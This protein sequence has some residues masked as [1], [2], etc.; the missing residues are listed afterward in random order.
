MLFFEG[1]GVFWLDGDD[2]AAVGERAIAAS[3]AH[4]IDDH[5]IVHG[6]GGDDPAARAH[7]KGVNAAV[8][9]LGG[10]AVACGGEEARALLA[11]RDVV[12]NLVDHRLGMLDAD[13]DGEGFLFEKD[14]A[15]VKEGVDVARAVA[16]GKNDGIGFEGSAIGTGDGAGVVLIDMN[17]GNFGE[18]MDF[19]AVV[20]DGVAQGLDDVGE[21]IRSDVGVGI[22]EDFFWCAVGDENLVDGMD[23]TAFGSAG[24]EFAI[25]EGASAAFAEA[26]VAFLD[27]AAF[28][29]EGREIEAASASIFSSFE[30][31]GFD[32]VF[33]AAESGE[34][35]GGTAADDDG[36][37]RVCWEGWTVPGGS[38]L[39]RE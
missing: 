36:A 13:A 12:L 34:D 30:D 38:R 17:V 6:G 14:V 24:V 20:N 27:D 1:L 39:G 4:T 19:A 25:G 16:S 10:E 15:S 32:T 37:T 29:K 8:S 7:T 31:D 21:E 33:E 35:A 22:G 18:E 28:T 26:V 5:F 9:D 3:E 11:T 2:H 23:R